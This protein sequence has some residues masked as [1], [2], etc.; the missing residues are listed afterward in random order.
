MSERRS[1]FV[2]ISHGPVGVLG[3][4]VAASALAVT[5]DQYGLV[6]GALL[7]LA[8]IFPPPYTVA[9]GHVLLVALD[10]NGLSPA[11]LVAVEAGLLA[12]LVD[13]SAS[14]AR[15]RDAVAVLT[16]VGLVVGVVWGSL[17]LGATHWTSVGLLALV[18]ALGSYGLHRYE[19]VR[20]DLVGTDR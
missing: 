5:A 20:F 1:G 16:A 12:S 4:I 9:L 18:V 7:V 8:V 17:R 2:T 14:T 10:P 11:A 13:A 19:L 6:G 15:G 3:V